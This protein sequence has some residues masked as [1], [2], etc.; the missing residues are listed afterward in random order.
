[1]S[2][3][4][5]EWLLVAARVF[6]PL[7]AILGFVPLLLWVER[8]GA[9]LIQD[10]PGPNRVGPY[11]L[12]Q[13]LADVIKFFFKEDII[14]GNADAGLYVLAPAVAVFSALTTF[15]VVPYGATLPWQGRNVPLI[16]A[17]VS[18]GLLYVFAITSL[19]V[20]GIVLAGWSSNNKFSL[21]GG[22]RSSAQIISYELAMTTAGAG[23]ILS[24]G[25][26]RLTEIVG[27]QNGTWLGFIP[28]WNVIPQFVGFVVFYV[29]AFAE[30]NRL[31]FDLPEAEA[32]LVAGYHT[33]YSSMKFAMFFMAEYINM[34]VAS[35][36]TVTL[37]FG[38]W[39]FPG[40]HPH[41][42]LGAVLSIV[43]FSVKT[44]FF[45]WVFVW[46]RWT[47]PRFRYDQ[48]MKLG[49]KVLLPL[50]LVNLFWTAALV[51]AG[52]L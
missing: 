10:R 20:Y 45:V 40:F 19:S 21:M 39:T 17:D 13:S 26:F 31:P 43:I 2:P 18:I 11:G 36:I 29:A 12:L 47:L 41:G 49:W 15:A 46:V 32:E 51:A 25:S 16:G 14:P 1:M 48:L 35:A 23:V 38:G 37:Y 9:G 22:I 8:R 44:L 3:A 33:E 50:A 27:A 7:L 24:A 5:T 52:K 34:I 6:V 4:A 28:R 42:V 30:T